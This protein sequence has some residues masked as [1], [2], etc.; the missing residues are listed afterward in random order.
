MV[1][2]N[3]VGT[4]FFV[5]SLISAFFIILAGK[6]KCFGVTYFGFENMSFFVVTPVV[7]FIVERAMFYYDVWWASIIFIVMN[8]GIVVAEFLIMLNS[9][10]FGK[11][12][13]YRLTPFMIFKR[14]SYGDVIGYKMKLTAG[15]VVRKFGQKTV[16]TYD[17]EIYLSDNTYISFSVK[18]DDNP[19]IAH[20]KSLLESHHCRRNG[21]IK[22]NNN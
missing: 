19:K 21:R 2:T 7:F 17:I 15:T 1:V 13:L 22:K 9:G 5:I 10:V 14:Y 6:L 16:K 18:N 4:A 11:N 20:I 3:I 12:N 8:T